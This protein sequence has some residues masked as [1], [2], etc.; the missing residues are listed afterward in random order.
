[1]VDDM[2]VRRIPRTHLLLCLAVLSLGAVPASAG[3]AQREHASYRT[4]VLPSGTVA[5]TAARA[6][7]PA[8]KLTRIDFRSRA[9]FSLAG[10]RWSTAQP[11]TGRMRA[12]TADGSWTA[13]TDLE[14]GEEG[15]DGV[16]EVPGSRAGAAAARRTAVIGREGST[17]PTWTGPSHRLQVELTSPRPRGLRAALVDVR[18]KIPAVASAARDATSDL[19]GIQPRTAWD[20]DDRCK[21]RA[22]ASI[23]SVQ[24]VVVHHTVNS[25]TYSQDQVPA[26]ILGICL[27]HRNS[28]GWNDI[29]YNVVVDRFGGAWEG[30][31]G[32]LTNAVIGA[33]A[34]GFN[35]V[36]AGISM[37]GDYSKVSPPP[38]QVATVE[39]VA[40]WKLAVAGV[41]RTGVVTLTSAGGSLS[42]YSEG[43]TVTLPRVFGHRDVGLTEC[44]GNVGYTI[45]DGVR[46]AVAA[47]NPILPTALP[48]LPATTPVPVSISIATRTRLAAGA[49]TTV[50]GHA[51]QGAAGLK[52]ATVALQVSPDGTAWTSVATARTASNGKY[53][54]RRKFSRSWQLRVVRT[55]GDGG[56][57]KTVAMVLVP[58]LSLT[59]PKRLPVN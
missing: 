14:S 16:A 50:A 45:L 36:T 39:R 4:A 21:P 3:A 19:A 22:N 59:V 51:R 49:T 2:F 5:A 43:Q 32:G 52:Q 38:A 18:G 33:Q 48:A 15:D 10:L 25:N 28:N 40:A 9:R 11:L 26:M 53:A 37:L 46:A 13:W 12:Q 17:E 58:T 1:M 47:A 31:A 34:Q 6:G 27:F 55:D 29:G 57:S 8:S 20:P 7:R 35:T 24:A 23:G 56:T 30:R 54:F 41:P 44:P 42:R